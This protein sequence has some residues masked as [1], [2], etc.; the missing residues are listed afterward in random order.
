MGYAIGMGTCYGCGQTFSFNPN[1]VPSLR[2]DGVR[3]PVCQVCMTKINILRERRG[4]KPF[5]IH[6]DAY[7]P[8]DEGEL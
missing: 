7:E 5:E 1:K 3:E 4:L 8:V 6:K 2:V